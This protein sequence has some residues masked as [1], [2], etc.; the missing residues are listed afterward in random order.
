MT[1]ISSKRSLASLA[2]A[3]LLAACGGGEP[4]D[5]TSSRAQPLSHTTPALA[6]APPDIA[7]SVQCTNLRIGAVT[8]DNVEVP[9]GVACQLDGTTVT[10]SVKALTDATLIVGNGAQVAGSI[11][12]DAAHH[13]ELTGKT[14]RVGGNFEV[15]KGGSAMLASAEVAGA[16]VFE[17]MTGTVSVGGAR[18]GGGMKVVKNTG[19]TT[20]ANNTVIGSLQCFDNAPAPLVGGNSADALEGQCFQEAS[21]PPPTPPSGN[22]TCVGLSLVGLNL[23]SVIV[24]DNASCTLI[25]STMNGTVQLGNN[26]RLIAQDLNITGNLIADG[27]AELSISGASRVGG[28]VQLN[29]GAGAS[30]SGVNIGGSLQIDAMPGAVT[31]SGNQ[32]GG[33]VQAIANRGGVTLSNNTMA[34]VLQ[35]LGNQPA[36]TGGGNVAAQKEGQC[37]GL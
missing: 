8:V 20:V 28:S 35:C 15:K 5:A 24:P 29:G 30:I 31:A 34:G 33:N 25:G 37:T 9:Q 19:A 27:A 11:V 14:S 7:G 12:G 22:V 36:P 6:D 32:I 26:A 21:P 1:T 16:A 10:G 13:V 18:A 4:A 3:T 17:E 2:A 23:D